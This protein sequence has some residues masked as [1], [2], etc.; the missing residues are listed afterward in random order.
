M[1]DGKPGKMRLCEERIIICMATHARDAHRIAKSAGKKAQH[2]Y[3]NNDGNKVFFEF[4][5]VIELI[6]CDDVLNKNEVWYDIKRYRQPMERR[7]KLIPP[8]DKLNAIRFEE[9]K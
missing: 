6:S 4:I 1:V 9:G 8:E 7:N 3:K 2:N 5:G